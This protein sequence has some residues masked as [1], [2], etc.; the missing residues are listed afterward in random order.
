M[1][2]GMPEQPPPARRDDRL[3]PVPITSRGHQAVVPPDG[4][5]AM[6][7]LAPVYGARWPTAASLAGSVA[8]LAGVWCAVAPFALD[9]APA[10]GG[11]RATGTT[12][13]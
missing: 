10:D 7:G 8:F 12:S 3:D 2:S 9:Y 6:V 4:S 1:T 13:S 11:S 5:A